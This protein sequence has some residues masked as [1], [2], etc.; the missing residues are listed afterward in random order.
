MLIDLCI[1]GLGNPGLKYFNTRHNI[2][3]HV[4]DKL[5]EFFKIESFTREE[6]FTAASVEYKEKNLILMKPLTF[7]NSSGKAVKLF[8]DGF[9]L[10]PDKF[11]IIYDDVN[12]SFGTLRLR[13]GGSDGGQN[14]IAS[15]IYEMETE[16]IPRLR[17]GIGNETELE[18][19]KDENGFDLAQFVLSEFTVE[20]YKNLDRIIN[21]AKDA[22]LCY[23][24]ESIAEAMNRY[25]RNILEP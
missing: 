4:I 21:E 16:D 19:L 9:G 10:R 22:V 12:L 24:N 25:N 14:G 1:A 5:A 15:I 8:A 3:F 23:V 2:G 7:M 11:L 17:I 18:K 20:E 13:P 6:I